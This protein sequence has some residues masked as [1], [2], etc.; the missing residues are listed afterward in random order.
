MMKF[1]NLD[2][3][4]KIAF[5]L[6][7]LMIC[8]ILCAAPSKSKQGTLKQ[9]LNQVESKINKVTKELR[10]KKAEK[11]VAVSQLKAQDSKLETAQSKIARVQLRIAASNTELDAINSKL[12]VAEKNLTRRENLLK[13][14]IVD[15]YEGG[16]LDYLN[17]FLNSTDMWSFVTQSYYIKKII[18]YDAKLVKD[19]RQEKNKILA[20]KEK[21]MQT[22]RSIESYK[23]TLVVLRDQEAKISKAKR[24]E[25]LAIEKDKDKLESML[26][27]LEKTSNQIERQI[28][29][30]QRTPK[31]QVSYSKAFRGGLSMPVSGRITSRFGGRFHPIRKK[32]TL[33]TGVDFAVPTGTS[34]KA[35]AAG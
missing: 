19:I 18:E 32:Y 22:I 6:C 25:V 5:S 10:Q 15:I 4:K 28:L 1:R 16:D 8:S 13:R 29:S 26:S 17:V 27:E 3:L 11:S 23:K 7:L 33:H 12:K 20:Q 30:F 2:I 9:K 24:A 34:I 31:G 14:R 21:K 35:A